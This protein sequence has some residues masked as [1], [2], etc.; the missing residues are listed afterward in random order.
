MSAEDLNRVHRRYIKV[1]NGFKSA[2][3]FHQFV[4]GLRKVFI[5][6]GPEAYQADF[7]SVYTELKGVSQN[8]SEVTVEQAATQLDEVEKGLAPLV[9]T[10]LTADEHISPGLLRQFFQRVKNYDD[11]ILSQLVKF[12]LYFRDSGG[13]NWDRLDKADYLSTKVCE[14]Y[15]DGRDTFILRDRTHIRELGQGFWAA[16][17]AEGVAEIEVSTLVQ[18]ISQMSRDL[19]AVESIEQ[20]HETNLL[21]RYRDFKHRLGD[22]FFQPKI[23]QAIVEANLV[24][25][26]HVQQLYRRDEQRI[27]AEYQQVFEL[28]RDV[29]VDVALRGELAEFREVVERFEGRIQGENVRLEEL[30]A[31]R[32]RVRELLP[33]LQ[34]KSS[35]LGPTPQPPEL[36]DLD[37]PA[38]G[39]PAAR[40]AI[41]EYVTTQYKAIV[42]ALDDTNNSLEPKKVVF[43]PEV[44]S[45]G[46]EPREVLAY[47]RLFSKSECDRELETFLLTTA[48]LRVRVE[49]DVEEIKSILDDTAVSRDAPAFRQASVTVRYADRALR[50]FEHL[51]DQ[52]VLVSDSS[53]ARS[54]QVLKMRVMRGY[55]GLWLRIYKE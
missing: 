46:L 38:A 51:I 13:W 42:A 30:A 39:Q 10:L 47:R 19:A 12:Y 22:T 31:L 8:L 15:Q 35:D 14:E 28:E 5:D 41:E 25:K 7:Q 34:P 16:L 55:A 37:E 32:E 54:L 33:Q 36:R 52:A 23:I 17:G 2:W 4:Q 21:Q 50:R 45:L 6:E 44:F 26:N 1:Q 53:E 49:L 11:N 40:S 29:S 18:E 48:A 20:L 24:S 27:V 9:Q 3:T 43:L